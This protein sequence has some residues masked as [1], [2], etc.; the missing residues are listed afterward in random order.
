MFTITDMIIHGIFHLTLEKQKNKQMKTRIKKIIK[1][2]RKALA[3]YVTYQNPF[4]R[5][6]EF[7]LRD[8]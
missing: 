5:I 6:N 1:Q 2:I 4:G 3:G 8:Q 7:S